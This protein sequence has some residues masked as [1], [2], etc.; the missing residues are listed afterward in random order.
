MVIY[1]WIVLENIL[2]LGVG[3]LHLITMESGGFQPTTFWY[4][5]YPILH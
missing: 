5:V 3:T 4:G 1:S 2:H